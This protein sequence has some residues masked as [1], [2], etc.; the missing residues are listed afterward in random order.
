MI[1][2]GVKTPSQ[3]CG[4][5]IAKTDSVHDCNETLCTQAILSWNARR[6]DARVQSGDSLCPTILIIISCTPLQRPVPPIFWC[7]KHSSPLLSD[8]YLPRKFDI[9]TQIY[10]KPWCLY[11]T[12]IND[13][14]SNSTYLMNISG[15]ACACSSASSNV[16]NC[17]DYYLAPF[18]AESQKLTC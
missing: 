17:R 5:K 3:W 7:E 6:R 11:I 4:E 16:G 8:L 13:P 10:F 2:K 15:C 12:R 1:T 18:L 14:L 9:F